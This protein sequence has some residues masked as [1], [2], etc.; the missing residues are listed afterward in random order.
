M[1]NEKDR[2]P[3]TP[4]TPVAM[5]ETPKPPAQPAPVEGATKQFSVK[6]SSWL[7]AFSADLE[8]P[9]PDAPL[10]LRPDGAEAAPPAA[11][12]AEEV[13]LEAVLFRSDPPPKP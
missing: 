1:P 8:E 13:S 5:G 12:A 4:A 6:M 2:P 3:V 9:P 11:P 10:D 7:A